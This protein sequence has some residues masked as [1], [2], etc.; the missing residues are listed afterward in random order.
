MPKR[1]SFSIIAVLI[2]LAACQPPVTFDKPQPMDVPSIGGFPKKIQGRYLSSRDSSVL[3][4]TANSLIRFY[5]FDLKL[6]ISQLDSTVQLIGDTLFDIAANRGYLAQIEGDSIIR[7]ISEADT[8]FSIDALNVL[9]KYKGYYFVNIFSSPDIW[10]VKKLDLS[11]GSL[12]LSSINHTEDIQQL[13]A[14][15]ESVQDTASYVFSPTRQEFKKFIRN[16]GFRQTEKFLKI[17]E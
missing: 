11:H 9:K 4:V 14:I 15:T 2:V 13:R 5:D 8:V 17:R 7:H 12:T 10:E 16:D 6:H 3:L 1:I